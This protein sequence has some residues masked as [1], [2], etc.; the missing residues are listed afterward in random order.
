MAISFIKSGLSNLTLERGR[1][2][3]VRKPIE[4]NQ[5]RYLTESLNEKIVNFGGTIELY[6]LEFSH[7][8]KD[9]YDGTIN[10]LKTWFSSSTINW[11]FNTFTLVDENG[12]NHIV[13]L[14]QDDFDMQMDSS[15]RYSL[16]LL[17]KVSS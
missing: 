13:R 17:L 10:G 2:Y 3:P 8:S 6:A 4:V 5:E 12:I 16:K 9:N 1:L 14:W 7:L 11:S 15:G